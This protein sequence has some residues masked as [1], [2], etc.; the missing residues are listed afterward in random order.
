[1]VYSIG[2]LP[3]NTHDHIS[4]KSCADCSITWVSDQ[5]ISSTICFDHSIINMPIAFRAM[6]VLACFC[7]SS[8]GFVRYCSTRVAIITNNTPIA[9]YIAILMKGNIA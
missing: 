7:I 3:L 9:K 8:D 2:R 4:H 1:M 5:N 6:S